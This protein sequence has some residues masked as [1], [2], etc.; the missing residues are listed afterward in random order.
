MDLDVLVKTALSN[1][2]SDLHLEAG[3]P[4]YTSLLCVVKLHGDGI[5]DLPAV[6]DYGGLPVARAG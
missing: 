1:G 4:P 5:F 2:A 3:L 6:V